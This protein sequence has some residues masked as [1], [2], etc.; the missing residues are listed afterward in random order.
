MLEQKAVDDAA[1][2]AAGERAG[3]PRLASA[4]SACR[5]GGDVPASVVSRSAEPICRRGGAGGERGGDVGAARDPAGGDE[6]QPGRASHR[7]EQ[8]VERSRIVVVVVERALVPPASAPWTTS[9]S[10]PGR[11]R[12]S[13]SPPT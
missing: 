7:V 11:G 4:P 6:R 8:G 3:Q 5:C 9:A 10:T 2:A 13:A 12:G 1:G